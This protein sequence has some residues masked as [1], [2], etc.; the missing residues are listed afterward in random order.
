MKEGEYR[1]NYVAVGSER[2]GSQE[3]F[4]WVKDPV[5]EGPNAWDGFWEA[6]RSVR[7]S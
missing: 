6:E 3:L 1:N 2:D 7:F 5:E 4:K